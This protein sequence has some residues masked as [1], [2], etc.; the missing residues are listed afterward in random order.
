MPDQAQAPAHPAPRQAAP[1][2]AVCFRRK[3]RR[4]GVG[5]AGPAA[6]WA[7]TA[8]LLFDHHQ[9]LPFVKVSLLSRYKPSSPCPRTRKT[10][11]SRGRLPPPRGRASR[12]RLPRLGM[13]RHIAGSSASL[14]GYAS[15][16][17][18][19]REI[20]PQTH[21]QRDT[22]PPRPLGA[23]MVSGSYQIM[24]AGYWGLSW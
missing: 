23:I 13:S 21:T 11:G 5:S 9:R 14:R 16:S 19:Q 10:M 17:P 20:P 12:T 4:H 3:H 7:S 18:W 22:D 8:T 24:Y 2:T 15:S 6:Y 1:P